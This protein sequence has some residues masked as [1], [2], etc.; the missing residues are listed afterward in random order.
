MKQR[1]QALTLLDRAFSAFTDADL[2][3]TAAST[4]SW[5]LSPGDGPKTVWAE[6]R[7]AVGNESVPVALVVG[8]DTT[9]PT[10]TVVVK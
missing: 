1:L 10:G 8:L 5:I 2:W 3:M 6:W 4:A 9:G 7:D